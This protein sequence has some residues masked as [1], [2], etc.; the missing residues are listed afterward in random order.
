MAKNKTATESEI[1]ERK[2]ALGVTGKIP[3]RRRSAKD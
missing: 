1:A 3:V 2:K